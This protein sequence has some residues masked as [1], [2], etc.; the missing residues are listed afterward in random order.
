[1]S[2]IVTTFLECENENYALFKYIATLRTE[3]ES[4]TLQK[5]ALQKEIE[6]YKMRSQQY[7]EEP[8]TIKFMELKVRERRVAPL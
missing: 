2:S 6:T 4:L 5:S 1:M 8:K 7:R 3:T